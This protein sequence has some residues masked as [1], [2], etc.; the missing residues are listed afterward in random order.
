MSRI[1]QRCGGWQGGRWPGGWG[2]KN[3]RGGGGGGQMGGGK[4]TEFWPGVPDGGIVVPSRSDSPQTENAYGESERLGQLK[5]QKTTQPIGVPSYTTMEM[6]V[7][8]TM[9]YHFSN[10]FLLGL[11]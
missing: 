1:W 10:I 2:T 8:I 11:W 5:C 4:T 7:L 6:Y 9:I 3:G